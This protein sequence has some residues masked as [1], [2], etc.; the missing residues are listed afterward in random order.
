MVPRAGGENLLGVIEIA[1]GP[2][3]GIVE[4]DGKQLVT[5]QPWHFD[6]SYNSELNRAGVLRSVKTAGS[7]GLTGFADGI[8]IYNDMD[9]QVREK[10]EGLELL[11]ILDLRFSR[12]RFGRPK[13]SREVR[14]HDADFEAM[15]ATLP[16]AIHPAVWT[17]ETGEKVLHMSPYGSPGINGNESA[18]GLAL[19][20]EIWDEVMR[21]M[22]PYYHQWRA[23]DMV[24]W[25]NWRML[26]EAGG[27]DSKEER[28][29]HRTTIK[30][31]YGL[32]RFEQPRQEAAS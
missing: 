10:V 21:V 20:E 9:P 6:H 11:H 18:K 3:A 28:I 1:T 17:R 14:P 27:C 13:N 30:G 4:I 32:G 31:D 25:D 16:R 29:V 23:T 8:Q 24:I 2:D 7:G 12:Q 26:H 5:W 15:A 19:L 22:Q